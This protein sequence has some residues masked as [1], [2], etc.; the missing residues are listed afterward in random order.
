VLDI[1]TR[2]APLQETVREAGDADYSAA[3]SFQFRAGAYV[4]SPFSTA[5]HGLVLR[6]L[7]HGP[8]RLADLRREIGGPAQ[9]TLR[10]NIRNL[11]A[12]GALEKRRSNGRASLVDHALTPAGVE[13]LFVA[14][15]IEA[16]LARAP[17][18]SIR[19][20]SET[21]KAA[22]KA[23]VG[24]W[25]STMLR[26]LAARPFSLTELDNLIAAFSYPALERR[27][28]AMRFS[29]CAMAVAGN[30]GGTPY[31]VT[32][33]LRQG[34]APLL[35][36]VRCERRHMAKQTPPLTR[37]DVE[38]ILLLS[39]PLVAF[40]G[41]ADGVAQLVVDAGEN[42]AGRSAGVRLAVRGGEL[43]G[44]TSKLEPKPESWIRGS[45]A[46]WLEALVTGDSGRLGVCGDRALTLD[47]VDA[48]HRALFIS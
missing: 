7:A 41:D 23:L 15:S 22:V 18:G 37:I 39:V 17:Q 44:C 42:S 36:S 4:L 32:D 35:A 13:L 19:L 14:D 9:T 38:T 6:A 30:G 10:G 16:W 29:G 45:A 40:A 20:E 5:L 3:C 11:V 43:A 31:A 46:D 25:D 26:A 1:G 21:G 8:K 33:W 48:M 12:I 34:M 2:A 47:C 28:G 27:L 24:G